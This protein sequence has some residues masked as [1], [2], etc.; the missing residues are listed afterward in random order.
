MSYFHTQKT[1]INHHI[2]ISQA[3]SQCQVVDVQMQNP[4]QSRHQSGSASHAPPPSKG[5][6]TPTVEEQMFSTG[7]KTLVD[8]LIEQ[9]KRKQK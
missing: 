1:T 6:I 7:N 8:Y 3:K 2:T 9:R 4:A 5:L